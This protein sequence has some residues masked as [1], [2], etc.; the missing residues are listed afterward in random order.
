MSGP[1]YQPLAGSH[2]WQRAGGVR[3]RREVLVSK[4]QASWC[5]ARRPARNSR[6]QWEADT[7]SQSR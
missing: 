5:S 3:H 6:V 7:P 2:D 4:R 1:R